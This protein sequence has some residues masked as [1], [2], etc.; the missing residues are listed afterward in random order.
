MFGLVFLSTFIS[1]AD[2]VT[3]RFQV[4]KHPPLTTLPH[5]VGPSTSST[6]SSIGQNPALCYNMY[7]MSNDWLGVAVCNI[8]S[9]RT[10]VFQKLDQG[11]LLLKPGNGSLYSIHN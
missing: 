3:M 1:T 5:P 6:N 11:L 7:S 8:F 4:N 10:Q 9:H 2:I